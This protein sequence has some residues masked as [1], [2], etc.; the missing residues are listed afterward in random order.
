VLVDR[1]FVDLA[2]LTRV[3]DSVVETL[4]H[5][6]Q[7]LGREQTPYDDGTVIGQV[8]LHLLGHTHVHTPSLTYRF[9]ACSVR[10]IG[11]RRSGFAGGVARVAEIPC[12]ETS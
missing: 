10:A 8:A 3:C 6:L 4:S 11:Q 12:G 2:W 9:V 7:L 1:S 5:P